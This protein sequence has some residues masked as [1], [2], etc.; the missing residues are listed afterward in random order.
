MRHVR[1]L[2]KNAEKQKTLY[3][4]T[5]RKKS[6]FR[7]VNNGD[8][9]QKSQIVQKSQIARFLGPWTMGILNKKVKKVEKVDF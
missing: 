3:K 7:A 6:I 8:F 9:E 1:S 5:M 4:K 2:Y